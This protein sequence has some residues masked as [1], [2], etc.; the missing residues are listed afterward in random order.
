MLLEKKQ[1]VKKEMIKLIQKLLEKEEMKS[2]QKLLKV[3]LEK[4]KYKWLKKNVSNFLVK[5]EINQVKAIKKNL[6]L[7]L[8]GT[9]I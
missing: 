4:H 2:I 1:L 3:I 8:M 6:G 9:F 5:K 7:T